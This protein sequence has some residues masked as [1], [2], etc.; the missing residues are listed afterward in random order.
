[1][2]YDVMFVRVRG[3]AQK[4]F[5]LAYDAVSQAD[6]ESALP[7]S[8]F[9]RWLCSVGQENGGADSILGELQPK[10]RTRQK[11]LGKMCWRK[12]R[13]S[14]RG[15]SRMDLCLPVWESR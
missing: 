5:P 6:L 8:E 13:I 7:W 11:P 14:V 3:A 4:S 9:R 2:G 15:S 1:M 10:S 12:R